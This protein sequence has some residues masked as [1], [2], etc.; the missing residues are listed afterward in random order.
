MKWILS[1]PAIC[2]LECS[3]GT[4][5]LRDW[6]QAGGGVIVAEKRDP[7]LDHQLELA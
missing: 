2:E 1:Q 4:L 5:L 6:K 3:G 7:T